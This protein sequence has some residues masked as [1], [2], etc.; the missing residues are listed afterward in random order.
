[1]TYNDKLEM[2]NFEYLNNLNVEQKKL[3]L[4]WMDHY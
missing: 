4:I 2:L 3:F 1:M